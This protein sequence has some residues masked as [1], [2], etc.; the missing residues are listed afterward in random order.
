MILDILKYCV[1]GGI[2]Y[3]TVGGLAFY[4]VGNYMIRRENLQRIQNNRVDVEYLGY[5]ES[6]GYAVSLPIIMIGGIILPQIFPGR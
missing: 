2:A 1:Y 5:L 6:C 3:V 4:L